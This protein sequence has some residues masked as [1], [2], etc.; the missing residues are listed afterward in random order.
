MTGSSEATAPEKPRHR[1]STKQRL[2]FFLTAW[3]IVL[4]PFLFWWNT[5]FGRQLSDKQLVEYLHDDKKPRHIQ[6]ALVQIGERMTKHDGSVVRWYPEVVQLAAH[7]VE[8]VRNTDAWVMGQDTSAAGFH[9]SLVKMLADLSLT[10]RGNAALSL[11]RFG[12][13]S[14]KPQIVAL[15]APVMVVAPQAGKVVD[16]STVGTAIHP[17]GVVAK[18][19]SGEVHSPVGG[20]VREISVQ[21]GQTVPEGQQVAIVAPAAEQVWEALRA[22]YM[23]GKLEDLPSIIPYERELPDIPDHV[24]QQAVLTEKAI[25]ERSK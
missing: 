8:E 14:G 10:V 11:V 6:H 4:M 23:I 12:D 13:A 9:E 2:L 7:R 16:T 17:S 24:R 25:R 19:D 18:L 20:R 22:L 5:W 3:L 1:M 21:V 15:L